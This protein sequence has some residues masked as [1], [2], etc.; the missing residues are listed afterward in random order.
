M[1]EYQVTIYRPELVTLQG[2]V[3][4]LNYLYYSDVEMTILNEINVDL[5]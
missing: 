3:K 2:I 4:I 5:N 1:E